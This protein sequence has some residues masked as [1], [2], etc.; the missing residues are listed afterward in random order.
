MVFIKEE[1]MHYLA[2][3]VNN[4]VVKWSFFQSILTQSHAHEVERS[5]Q[6]FLPAQAVPLI[7]IDILMYARKD[8]RL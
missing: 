5:F 1:P 6:C 3:L 8:G 4:Y 2:T 7:L